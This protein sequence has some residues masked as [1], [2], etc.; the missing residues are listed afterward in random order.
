MNHPTITIPDEAW[1]KSGSDE[2]ETSRLLATLI[3]NGVH[4][5]LEAYALKPDQDEQTFAD[6]EFSDVDECFFRITDTATEK[7]TIMG[8]EYVLLAT[9]YGV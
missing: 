8:R 4:M 6:P 1:A 5:H 9:P 3:I 2:D 7:V